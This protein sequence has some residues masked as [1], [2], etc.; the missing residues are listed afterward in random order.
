M[1]TKEPEGGRI[2]A[3]MSKAKARKRLDEASKK[4]INVYV[5][6]PLSPTDMKKLDNIHRELRRIVMRLK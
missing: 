3:T 6:Y 4:C 5:N 2:M 1:Y